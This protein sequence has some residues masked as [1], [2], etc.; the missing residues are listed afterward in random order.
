MRPDPTIGR[1]CGTLFDLAT[2]ELVATDRVQATNELG[3][4]SAAFEAQH[5]LLEESATR[6]VLEVGANAWPFPI[7][8]VHRTGCGL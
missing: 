2:D 7:P 1:L 4:F 6:R 8:I 3:A 5:R